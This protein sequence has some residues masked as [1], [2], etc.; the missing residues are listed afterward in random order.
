MTLVPA[1]VVH[2]V[3]SYL[4]FHA[5]HRNTR[6][7]LAWYKP[8]ARRPWRSEWNADTEPYLDSSRRRA[9]GAHLLPIRLPA[10]FDCPHCRDV[11][12]VDVLTHDVPAPQ[13][14]LRALISRPSPARRA[15]TLTPTR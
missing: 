5:Q 10:L 13:D 4:T 2:E 9:N 15:V 14:S 12:R 7:G 11:V 6:G 1:L 3:D 8:R